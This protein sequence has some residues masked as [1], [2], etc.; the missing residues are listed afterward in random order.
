MLVQTSRRT[1]RYSA[2]QA[3]E[4]AGVSYRQLDYWVRV[5]LID[6]SQQAQGSGTRRGFDD[7][8][9]ADLR[10]A[11]LLMRVRQDTDWAGLVLEDW[12][13]HLLVIHPDGNCELDGEVTGIAIVVALG[14]LLDAE[15]A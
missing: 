1:P 4:L 5:G 8:D 12:R 6:V 11:S 7:R 9:L 13:D 15:A 3:A 2:V 10:L 14:A